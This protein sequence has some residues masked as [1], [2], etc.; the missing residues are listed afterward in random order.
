M[1]VGRQMQLK[2]S[3]ILI[4]QITRF[5]PTTQ[6]CRK[7]CLEYLPK[8]DT[9]ANNLCM[10]FIMQPLLET[11]SRYNIELFVDYLCGI[12]WGAR[13]WEGWA[14]GGG[15]LLQLKVVFLPSV[16]GGSFY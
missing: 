16:V 14:G 7:K 2:F 12:C 13:Y 5:E 15:G 9:N 4:S 6:N 1:F 10:N 8:D 3:G 11:P